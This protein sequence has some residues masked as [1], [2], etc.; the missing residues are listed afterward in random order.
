MVTVVSHTVWTEPSQVPGVW[1]RVGPI[2]H[3]LSVG[4]D[5]PEGVGLVD[6]RVYLPF[7]VSG[8]ALAAFVA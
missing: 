3:A 1:T 6:F 5:L 8:V 7:L 4:P 2:N